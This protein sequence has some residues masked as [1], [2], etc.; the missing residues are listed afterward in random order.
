MKKKIIIAGVILVLCIG[1]SFGE[2]KYFT[3]D[4]DEKTLK[5]KEDL[6][7]KEESKVIMEAGY[8]SKN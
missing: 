3:K 5:S 8:V 6:L 7:S 1:W 4:A 2:Y